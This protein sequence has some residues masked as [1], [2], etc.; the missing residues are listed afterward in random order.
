MQGRGVELEAR[1]VGHTAI[2][3]P[4]SHPTPRDAL[5]AQSTQRFVYVPRRAQR[6][7][8]L[9]PCT[10][11]PYALVHTLSAR[12]VTHPPWILV[13]SL[14]QASEY[15]KRLGHRGRWSHLPQNGAPSSLLSHWAGMKPP[16]SAEPPGQGSQASVREGAPPPVGIHTPPQARLGRGGRWIAGWGPAPLCFDL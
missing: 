15:C 13:P 8:E 9:W 12:V 4:P 10:H 2:C 11:T 14:R 1:A 16:G 5:R 7:T 3:L 6:H